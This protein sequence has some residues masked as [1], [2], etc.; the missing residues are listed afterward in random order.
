VALTQLG[1]DR[2]VLSLDCNRGQ[3]P[4]CR[5]PDR[6]TCWELPGGA[7][8]NAVAVGKY[9]SGGGDT[10]FANFGGR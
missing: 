7:W 8:S 6:P 3:A 1:R 2:R 10:S 5:R 4:G 9:S